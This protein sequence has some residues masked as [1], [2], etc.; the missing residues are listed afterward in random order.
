MTEKFKKLKYLLKESIRIGV[1]FFVN[2]HIKV[3]ETVN[4]L[5][6]IFETVE[7]LSGVQNPES[8][9]QNLEFRIQNPKF[10][11]QKL[12]LGRFG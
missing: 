9:I 8:R 4:K 2:N 5:K 1:V 10:I 7:L 12:R 6:I 11:I 3:S